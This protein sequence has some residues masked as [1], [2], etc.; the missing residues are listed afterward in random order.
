MTEFIS[1]VIVVGAGAAGLAAARRLS[2]A[3]MRVE[4]IE[5]RDRLGGRIHTLR[6]P[7]C[8]VP[9]E[10]GAEFVHGEPPETWS[11]ILAAELAAY[12][13]EDRH[14]T[15]RDAKLEPLSLEGDWE[16][17]FDRISRL[18][19]EE[20]SF[21]EFL[22]RHCGD[23]PEEAKTQA[24]AYVEGFNAADK[25]VVSARWIGQSEQAASGERSFRLPDGYGRVVQWLAS[26][27][28]PDRA[29]VR[30]NAIARRIEWQS[31]RVEAQTS[32]DVG[33]LP[34]LRARCAIITLPL[35]VL[36]QA[37]GSPGAVE[38][39]PELPEKRS[40]W[41]R[42]RMGGVVKVVLRFHEPFWERLGHRELAF[43]HAPDQPI[44]T[45]WTTRPM[46]SA[47][48]TGWSGGAQV[49]ALRGMNETAIL[50]VALDELSQLFSTPREELTGLLDG[51]NVF[52]WRIDPFS[53][54]AYSYM[55]AGAEDSIARI[56]APVE[57][58]LF[59]AGEHTDRRQMGTVAG[60]ISSGYRVAEEVLS[61]GR[62]AHD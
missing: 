20:L 16:R 6:P 7:G 41:N 46:Q 25:N 9:I 44:V 60:A 10:A 61:A 31:G 59:F 32:S 37:P 4:V 51:W 5:A 39:S 27:L 56:T 22:D 45:W 11:I 15:Y 13:I 3:G 58:T 12:E 19:Q 48:L 47:V 35:G 21:A 55:P 54:G 30:L 50:G 33:E 42:L 36:Q 29:R 43:L 40:A 1:D 52:D 49:D 23:I 17:I 26:G 24:V 38:F 28:N 57:N 34:P 62:T 18:G 8:P 53:R 2:A 14:L